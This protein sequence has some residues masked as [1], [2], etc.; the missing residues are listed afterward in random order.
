M[1]EL[2]HHRFPSMMRRDLCSG[3]WFGS[4]VSKPKL[5]VCSCVNALSWSDDGGILLSGSDDKRYITLHRGSRVWHLGSIAEASV[6][7]CGPPTPRH[8]PIAPPAAH[9]IRSSSPKPSRR[10]ITP[11]SFLPNSFLTRVH[12]RSSVWREIGRSD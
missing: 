8:W 9:L 11:I 7:V 12:L 1:G 4:E 6:S 2:L 10:G 3:V 5:T